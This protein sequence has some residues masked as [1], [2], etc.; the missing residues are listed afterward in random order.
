MQVKVNDLISLFIIF[1]IFSDF[2]NKKY[3]KN[4][5]MIYLRYKNLKLK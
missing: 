2:N 5:F 3:S 1:F 4:K